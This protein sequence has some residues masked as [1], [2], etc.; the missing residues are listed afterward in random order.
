MSIFGSIIQYHIKSLK[1]DV[2][3]LMERSVFWSDVMGGGL[4]NWL[5]MEPG[6]FVLSLSTINF[7]I[8]NITGISC[9]T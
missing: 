4:Q 6:S 5:S 3:S 2:E 1:R 9:T 7:I 8:L